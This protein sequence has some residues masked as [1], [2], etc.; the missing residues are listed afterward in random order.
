MR[1]LKGYRIGAISALS[2]RKILNRLQEKSAL[3]SGVQIAIPRVPPQASLFGQ[4]REDSL[5]TRDAKCAQRRFDFG[6]QVATT[7]LRNRIDLLI[8]S[9]NELKS[10]AEQDIEIVILG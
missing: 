1:N 2:I 10:T 3:D 7:D 4:F 8:V 5:R 9:L 6:A